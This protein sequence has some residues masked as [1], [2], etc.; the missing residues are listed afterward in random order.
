MYI[1]IHIYTYIHIYIYMSHKCCDICRTLH[2]RDVASVVRYIY[3]TWL[4]FTCDMTSLHSWHD[5]YVQRTTSAASEA[6][7][8]VPA[9]VSA[10]MSIFEHA[11][12]SNAPGCDITHLWIFWARQDLWR[13][14]TWLI[15]RE[16]WLVYMWD[17]TQSYEWYYTSVSILRTPRLLTHMWLFIVRHV[18]CTCETWLSRMSDTTRP[19]QSC[20]FPCR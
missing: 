12:T 7:E 9:S 13:T 2:I 20:M 16:T 19:N 14:D 4:V 8:H 5:S 10:A 6:E 3:V 17:W 18:L 11:K 1:Y 15:H